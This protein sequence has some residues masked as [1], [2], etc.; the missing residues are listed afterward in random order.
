LLLSNAPFKPFS[1]SFQVLLS[2]PGEVIFGHWA[3]SAARCPKPA[4][5]GP[6]DRRWE[7][8]LDAEKVSSVLTVRARRPGDRL[9]PLGMG[10]REKKL[11]DVLVD[12]KI[13]RERRDSLPLVVDELDRILWVVGEAVSEDFRVTEPSRA[14]I[15]LKARRLGGQG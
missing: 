10:G 5:L 9:K 6:G 8:M 11:Q 13:E 15:F 7:A 14:V 2:I 4:E 1:N 3:I 12:R